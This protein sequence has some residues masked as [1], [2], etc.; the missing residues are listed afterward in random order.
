M[1]WRHRAQLRA[2]SSDQGQPYQHRGAGRDAKYSWIKAPRWRGHAVE[3]GPLSRYTLA[4]AQD[5]EYVKEQ[6]HRSVTTFNNRAHRRGR[7]D[8]TAVDH[9]P[10]ADAVA[11]GAILRR[12][13]VDH[14]NELIANIKAGETATT[15]MDKWDP[16]TWPRPRAWVPWPHHASG[17]V[18]GIESRMD[19]ARMYTPGITW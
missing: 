4:Y 12:H 2:R 18:A 1:G 8:R 16:S 13:L 19:R 3:V 17:W 14:W 15:N 5:V 9:R 6:V 7:Q 10:H 11:G